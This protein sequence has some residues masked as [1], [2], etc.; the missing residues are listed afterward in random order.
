MKFLAPILIAALCAQAADQAWF[1]LAGFSSDGEYLAWESG[2]VQDGSGF[3]WL[4][5]VILDTGTSREVESSLMVLEDEFADPDLGVFQNRRNDLLMEF[6]IE[7]PPEEPLVYRP[8]TDL[9][10][11]GDSLRFCLEYYCPGY[12]SD[13]YLLC[14]ITNSLGY[15]KDYPDWFPEPVS[16]ELSLSGQEFFSEETPPE[17][18]RYVFG[19]GF[20][21]VYRNPVLANRLAAVLHTVVPGF[22][23]ADG[24]YRVVS[25]ELR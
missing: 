8:L 2:G 3:P 25:G 17:E 5:V 20:A 15:D 22:E 7:V 12:W 4:R 23:G 19:Y 11:Q 21:A 24:R 18:Y 10:V 9:T 6:G 1:R 13:E 14:L 16:L